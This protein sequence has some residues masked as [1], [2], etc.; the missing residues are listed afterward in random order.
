MKNIPKTIFL[1]VGFDDDTDIDF[2][3]LADVTWSTKRINKADIEFNTNACQ[4]LPEWQI[5]IIE[6]DTHPYGEDVEYYQCKKC[7]NKSN[8][9]TK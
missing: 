5:K 4:C 6:Y 9:K 7:N 1:N 2:N 3:N 8:F